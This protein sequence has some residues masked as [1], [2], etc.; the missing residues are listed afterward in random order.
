[1]K[2][3]EAIEMLEREKKIMCYG[4]VHPQMIGWCE[5]YCQMPEAFDIAIKAL[6]DIDD[7][8]YIELDE[9]LE[10]MLMV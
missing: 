7:G 5:D 2:N 6:K 1:M 8:K 10:N 4:C 3:K 9:E